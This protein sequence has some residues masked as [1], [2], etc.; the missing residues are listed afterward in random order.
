MS[1]GKAETTQLQKKLEEQLERLVEQLADLEQVHSPIML[2][3][4]RVS[5]SRSLLWNVDD[6]MTGKYCLFLGPLTGSG[7]QKNFPR[8][9]AYIPKL[10][11]SSVAFLA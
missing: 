2:P 6:S 7:S 8:S 5:S 10:I 9:P 3:R 4:C 11:N 1:R